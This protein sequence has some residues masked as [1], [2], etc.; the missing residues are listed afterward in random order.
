[1]PRDHL[2]PLLERLGCIQKAAVTLEAPIER[3]KVLALLLAMQ[4]ARGLEECMEAAKAKS[5][6]IRK[7]GM[8]DA[9]PDCN[10]RFK[11]VI[12]SEVCIPDACPLFLVWQDGDAPVKFEMVPNLNEEEGALWDTLPLESTE[13][14]FGPGLDA[15]V[16]VFDAQ[17]RELVPFSFSGP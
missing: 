3:G 15:G 10:K 4:R 8:L 7:S 14:I 6:Q 1:M 12:A 5:K 9:E 2:W 17:T 16:L 11:L 13:E